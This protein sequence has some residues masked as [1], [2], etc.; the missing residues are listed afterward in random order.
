MTLRPLRPHQ[1]RTLFHTEQEAVWA[2]EPAH[3]IW[4]REK[5]LFATGIQTPVPAA[6]S[7]ASVP[8][9]VSQHLPKFHLLR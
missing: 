5:S 9:V 8:T 2:P 1:K 3:A 4:S 7:P 6:C